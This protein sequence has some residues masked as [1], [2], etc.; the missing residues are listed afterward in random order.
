MC[1]DRDIDSDDFDYGPGNE[2]YEYD[3]ARQSLLDARIEGR[4]AGRKG[5]SVEMN[6]YLP[7][8]A[9]YTQWCDGWRETILKQR[10]A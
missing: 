8:D 5:L 1:D 4:E 9:E 2:D 10:A 7:I 6:P 3:E